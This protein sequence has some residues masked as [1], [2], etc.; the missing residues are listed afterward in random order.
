[1]S[2]HSPSAISVLLLCLFYSAPSSAQSASPESIAA[3]FTKAWNSHDSD[4]HV[5]RVTPDVAVV[6]FHSTVDSLDA[7]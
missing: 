6:L 4:V 1:M 2:R 7:Q 5:E 3:D